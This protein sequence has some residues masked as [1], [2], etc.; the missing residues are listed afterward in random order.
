MYFFP[1]EECQIFIKKFMEPYPENANLNLSFGGG[2]V[3]LAQPYP[4]SIRSAD[5]Q[6][7]LHKAVHFAEFVTLIQAKKCSWHQSNN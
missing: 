4:A 2:R 3:K 7:P 6:A 5:F 1:R